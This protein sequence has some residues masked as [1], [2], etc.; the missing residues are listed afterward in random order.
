[1]LQKAE[2]L[3]VLKNTEMG[4]AA[5]FDH[6]ETIICVVFPT[7]ED[8][9]YRVT[10]RKEHV[11]GGQTHRTYSAHPADYPGFENA[12]DDLFVLLHTQRLP[13]R[14]QSAAPPDFYT[15]EAAKDLFKL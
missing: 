5:Y 2:L 11:G 3:T 8:P 14:S 10:T 9:V 1:M 13:G 7:N 6:S 4:V 15:L 12:L